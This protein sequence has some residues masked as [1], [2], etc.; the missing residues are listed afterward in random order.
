MGLS[1]IGLRNS[2]INYWNQQ[3]NID[4]VL[5]GHKGHSARP[6]HLED[7]TTCLTES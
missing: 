5:L 7:V 4:D 1:I 2:T 6:R 3:K